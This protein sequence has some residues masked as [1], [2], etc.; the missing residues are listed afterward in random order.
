MRVRIHF[1]TSLFIILF[2]VVLTAQVVKNGPAM[3]AHVDSTVHAYC[4]SWAAQSATARAQSLKSV[5]ADS[6]TYIDATPRTLVGVQG[7]VAAMEDFQKRHPGAR[8]R[9][10][11]AQTHHN[12]FRFTW[13]MVDANEKVQLVGVDF[14]E[15]DP[16][17]HIRRLIGFFGPPPEVAR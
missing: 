9:C 3:P 5:W 16:R 1:T 13:E 8:F 11:K 7:L 6:A 15:L 2:P 17:G 10:S 4:A 12:V 14:G